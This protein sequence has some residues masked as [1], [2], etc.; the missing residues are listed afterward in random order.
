[1]REALLVAVALAAC[2]GLVVYGLVPVTSKGK[3][4]GLTRGTGD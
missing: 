2:V 1:M 4:R 3:C